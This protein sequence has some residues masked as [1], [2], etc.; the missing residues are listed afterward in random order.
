MKLVKYRAHFITEFL[1]HLPRAMG[2]EPA[3]GGCRILGSCPEMDS[4]RR[5]GE[6]ISTFDWSFV[7]L[8]IWFSLSCCNY[9]KDLVNIFFLCH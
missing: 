3:R 5:A 4:P 8:V 2:V 6:C 9:R 1:S 7:I